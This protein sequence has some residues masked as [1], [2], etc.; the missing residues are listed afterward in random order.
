[1][2]KNN[3]RNRNYNRNLRKVVFTIATS[4]LEVSDWDAIEAIVDDICKDM[5]R[6]GCKVTFHRISDVAGESEITFI[7]NRTNV[8]LLR[9]QLAKKHPDLSID[10]TYDSAAHKAEEEDNE[11]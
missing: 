7:P 5:S 3:Y 4:Y 1:M 8:E 9:N 11:N 2:R 6:R 10:I